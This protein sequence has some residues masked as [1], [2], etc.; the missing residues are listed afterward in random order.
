MKKSFI[1]TA[2][3]LARF[4]ISLASLC[5]ALLAVSIPS[6]D[7]ANNPPMLF[8]PG[9]IRILLSASGTILLVSSAFL[10]DWSIDSFCDNDW[11]RL[12]EIG[13]SL[14]EKPLYRGAKDFFARIRLFGGGYVL[15]SV[16]VG[17]LTFVMLWLVTFQAKISN[18]NLKLA[19]EL[20]AGLCGG[21]IF[22]KMM[23]RQLG[24]VAWSLILIGGLAF[25]SLILN[26][27]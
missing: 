22:V 17:F 3:S 11:N 21:S 14:G 2:I 1:D 23:A 27:F 8:I 24:T 18:N 10:L 13:K 16:A 4:S 19:S 15:L 20:F 9:A 5:L 25:I 6:G 26:I 7:P 12:D